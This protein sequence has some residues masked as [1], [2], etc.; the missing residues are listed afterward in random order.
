MPRHEE[1]VASRWPLHIKF[2]SWT[3]NSFAMACLLALSVIVAIGPGRSSH[4]ALHASAATPNSA[5]TPSSGK[6]AAKLSGSWVPSESTWGED[7]SS[8]GY[9]A[10]RKSK[11][12]AWPP[13][14]EPRN[15]LMRA[16][17]SASSVE[18][19]SLPL[20]GFSRTGDDFE[21]NTA[22]ADGKTYRTMC[23]RLCDGFYWPINYAVTKDKFKDDASACARTCGGPGDAKLFTYRNPGGE[24]EDMEDSDGRAY[25]KLQN[26]FL[27]RTKYEPTCKCRAHPWEETATDRHKAYALVQQVQKGS[28]VAAQELKV[29]RSKMQGVAKAAAKNKAADAKPSA[30]GKPVVI[31]KAEPAPQPGAESDN[32]PKIGIVR[33]KSIVTGAVHAPGGNASSRH[34]RSALPPDSAAVD[35]AQGGSSGVVILRYGTSAPV[36]VRLQSNN[37][38]TQAEAVVGQTLKR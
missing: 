5:T 24:I 12:A 28:Q 25:R 19:I 36:E 34:F 29:L 22:K 27:F 31:V 2:H 32:K 26:A 30:K 10:V 18:R 8:P 23:V 35:Q 7:L 11:T 15:G 9:W 1:R 3:P 16:A 37:R 14:N 21:D 38:A 33:S 6:T 20:R 4:S 13:P 17:P